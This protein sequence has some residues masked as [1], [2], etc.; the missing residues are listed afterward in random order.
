MQWVGPSR[1]PF[2]RFYW[3]SE[4]AASPLRPFIRSERG[5]RKSA[6]HL[7]PS[8]ASGFLPPSAMEGGTL[9]LLRLQQGCL[10]G[11]APLLPLHLR[12][13]SRPSGEEGGGEVVDEVVDGAEALEVDG[14]VRRPRLRRRPL[15]FPRPTSGTTPV[16]S[17]SGC[18]GRLAAA[19]A[20]P[21]RSRACWRWS[22]LRC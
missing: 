3:R 2:L 5:Q 1:P 9:V 21:L 20:F 15:F 18:A 12:R 4:A 13:R 7:L 14:S 22:S 10:L 11:N 17:S 19:S 6:L 16:S 8:S